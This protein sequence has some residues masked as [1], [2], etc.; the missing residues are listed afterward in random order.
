MKGRCQVTF[1]PRRRLA[2]MSM[3]MYSVSMKRPSFIVSRPMSRS[4]G[5]G[6]YLAANT[7]R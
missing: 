5:A 7:N 3:L 1:L 6:S 4:E 2:G